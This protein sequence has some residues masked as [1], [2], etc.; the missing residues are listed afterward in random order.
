MNCRA[1]GL[2]GAAV[3]AKGAIG[4]V[5]TGG[6][7]GPHSTP[8]QQYGY[9]YNNYHSA[10]SYTTGYPSAGYYSSQS[11]VPST[12]TANYNTDTTYG[13]GVVASGGVGFAPPNYAL[14]NQ[15]QPY[16]F[17]NAGPLPQKAVYVVCDQQ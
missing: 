12:Y 17:R 10:P 13:S 6:A 15:I 5:F 7:G 2:A 1:L 16:A 9:G 14:Q 11:V 8:S 4:G 3:A